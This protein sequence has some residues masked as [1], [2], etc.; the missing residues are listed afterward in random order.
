MLLGG[1]GGGDSGFKVTGVV[2]GFLG[3]V[4]CFTFF[5]LFLDFFAV[6]R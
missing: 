1:G 4:C 2:E 3:V 5:G 6:S